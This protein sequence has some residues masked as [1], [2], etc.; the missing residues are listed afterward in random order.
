MIR[1]DRPGKGAAVRAGLLA[2]HAPLVGFCDVDMAT[3]LSALDTAILLLEAGHQVVIG[4]RALEASDVESRHSV[5]R[6]WGARVFRDMAR[7]L[8]PGVTDTQCG[9]KF[10]AGPV[11]RAAAQNL[12]TA[13]YAFDI[14]LLVR[15]RALGAE[16]AEIPVHWRDVPGSTFSAWRHSISTF[17]DVAGI[18][19]GTRQLRR[20]AHAPAAAAPAAASLPGPVPHIPP[21][22][23][24]A[25]PVAAQAVAAQPL[26]P[27]P[28]SQAMAP[29][30]LPGPLGGAVGID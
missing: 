13:G 28:M 19:L 20:A 12:T 17:R 24:A 29:Q 9:F 8:V 2:T 10:F 15:C 22:P 4:S 26:S 3:D 11:A 25:H 18:W 14:E 6:T 27:H 5:L 30:P 23:V 7:G 21:V 1:V 16:P